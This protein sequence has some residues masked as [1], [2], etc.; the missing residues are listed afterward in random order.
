MTLIAL[1]M[2]IYFTTCAAKAVLLGRN[3]LLEKESS[4]ACV[5]ALHTMESF[6]AIFEPVFLEHLLMNLVQK[7]CGP[8]T[9]C[10]VLF[11]RP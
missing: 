3:M 9:R 5:V 11:S 2:T 8:L 4:S 6:T 7:I 1:Y 10:S